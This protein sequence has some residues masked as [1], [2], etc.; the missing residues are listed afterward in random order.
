TG[1]WWVPYEN[2]E[3]DYAIATPLGE[4]RAAYRTYRPESY[5]DQ[6]F[7][8]RVK[9]PGGQPQVRTLDRNDFDDI[10]FI[11]EYPIATI[12]YR[13]RQKPALPVDVQA[14]V[15][16]PLVPLNTRDS[17]IPATVLRYMVTNTSDEPVDVSIA[18]WLQNAVC[19]ELA[20]RTRA[21]SRNRVVRRAAV[22][23]VQMDLVPP[24]PKPQP[25]ARVRVIE[26]F[27]TGTYENWE[28]EGE[29]F[30]AAPASGTLPNQQPMSGWKGKYF[31]NTYLGGDDRLQGRAVSKTFK[32][33]EPYVTFLIGSGDH[34]D[35]TC[36]NLVVDGKVVRTATG[37][38][39]VKLTPGWWD[40]NELIGK[41]AQ[42]HIVDRESAPWGH[43]AV[44]QICQTNRRPDVLP[45]PHD[46]AQFGDMALSALD[47]QATATAAWASKEAFLAHLAEHGKLDGRPAGRSPLGEK[48]CGAVASAFRLAPGESRD[49]TFL[50]SWY[51][52]NRR[53]DNGGVGWAM[54]SGNGRRVG[55][56]YSNWFDSSLDVARYV[57]ENFDRL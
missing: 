16:S 30:G 24:A 25:P 35:R 2:R 49:A 19:L 5:V 51:F 47:S 57:A 27:E 22:T 29:A 48:Q 9:T 54:P 8:I 39:N 31:V 36:L 38:R 37:S 1:V 14:E 23:S 45:F 40:V 42:I 41:Q 43:I 28:V 32:I 46:H 21:I 20:D 50:L 15:F 13:S 10:H 6:G 34:K 55:N 33:S 18:G 7:A 3:V 52:P 12:E 4:H 53:Q 56:M 11:G 17:A 26:D 44:D